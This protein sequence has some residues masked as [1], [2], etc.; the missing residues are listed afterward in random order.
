MLNGK[1]IAVTGATGFV[2]SHI[3][4]ALCERRA[5]VVGVVRTPSKGDWLK[6]HGVS[7]RK[8]D[9]AHVDALST[10]FEG[11]DVVVANAGLSAGRQHVPLQEFLSANLTGTRNVLTAAAN[12]GVKRVLYVSSV[13]VY[14]VWPFRLIGEDTPRRS[15]LTPDATW[16]TTHPFYALSKAKGE[17]LA[18]QLAEELGLELTVFRPGPVYGSRDPKYTTDVLRSVQRWFTFAPTVR[19]PQVHAGDLAAAMATS[20]GKPETSGRA[21]NLGGRSVSYLET[22]RAAR[23]AAGSNVWLIPVPL[24]VWVAFDDGAAARDLGFTNRSAAQGWREAFGSG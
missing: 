6:E 14:K 24:P 21:Y 10:A 18:W 17:D 15:R 5:Q 3:A 9:L 8:A 20:A 23:A 13:S 11:C 22:L 7:F 12:A 4:L 19:A 2:G 16:F 1:T